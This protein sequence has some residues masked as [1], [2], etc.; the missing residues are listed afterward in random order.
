MTKSIDA[1]MKFRYLTVVVPDECTDGSVCFRAEHPQLPG[2]MSHGATR[3]EA[4]MNL[5][6]A[7]RLYIETLLD[8]GLDVP[9]PAQP[10]GGTYSSS[11]SILI[12]PSEKPAESVVELPA[13]FDML[14]NAAA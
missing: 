11:E 2:C 5:A 13:E 9:I 1:Y 12:V 7:K 14:K 6:E 4:I 10:T 3:E 8:K